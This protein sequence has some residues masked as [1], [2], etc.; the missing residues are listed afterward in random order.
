[1]ELRKAYKESFKKKYDVNLGFL[2]FFAKAVA[3]GLREFPVINAQIQGDEIV[4]HDYV[5]LG[6]AV[7]TPKGLMVPV[8]R[9]VQDLSFNEIEQQI[10]SL[11]VKGRDGKINLEDLSE[12]TF[13]ITNGGVFGSM[14]ST[15]ILNRPQSGILGIFFCRR[16]C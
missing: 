8:I 7:S 15:P 4:Y 9:N 16:V 10:A 2:S 12:G 5:N 13:T 14:L 3:I 1:M 11:A 6:I